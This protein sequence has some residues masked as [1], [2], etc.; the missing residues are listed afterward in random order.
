VLLFAL[1]GLLGLTMRLT[2]ADVLGVSP[3]WFYRIMT[4]HGAG[5]LAGALLAMMG[6]LWLVLR[7][8]VPLSLG[9]MLVSY[10]GVLLGAA[11]VVIATIAGGF[12][13]GWTFLWPLPFSAA[14]EWSLWATVVFLVGMLVIGAGFFI[15]CVDVLHRV[16]TTYGG[17]ARALGI[18]V[19]RG[20]PEEAPPPQA[21]AATVTAIFGLVA[22]AV[23]TTMLMTLVIRAI[24]SSVGIDALWAKNLTY[25]FGHTLANLIIYLGAGVVYVLVP[26][27]AGRPWKTTTPLV[28]GWLITLVL[29][30]SVYSHHLYM[31][32]VQPAGLQYISMAASFGSALPVAVVTIFTG[33]M[34]IWGSR[35][36]WTL[37]STLLYLGFVGW[38]I[39][40]AGAVIDSVIPL[41]FRLHN[42]L[43]VPGHFHTYLLL[44]VILWAL[45][46]LA[47][48]LERAAGRPAARWPAR[49]A[50]VGMLVGGYGLVAAWYVSGALGVPRRYAVHP[51]GTEGYSLAASI[52]TMVFALGFL[53][54]LAEF[55]A[56]ARDGWARRP[57]AA[58]APPA[59]TSE[60][61]A[62]RWTEFR[63]RLALAPSLAAGPQGAGPRAPGRR[64][65]GPSAQ[66]LLVP[67]LATPA[68]L[69]LGM[70]AAVAAIVFFL[71]AVADP[72]EDHVQLHH[73]AHAGQF[74]FGL[75]LGL[76]LASLPTAFA[77]LSRPR[78]ASDAGLAAAIV[79]PLVMLLLM[80][81]SIYES[82]DA[83][84]ALHALYH[85]GIAALGLVTGVGCAVLGR[86]TGFVVAVAS[87]G[88]AVVFA[89]GVTGG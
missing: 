74:L 86:L 72:G 80:T 46:L 35:Y 29:V 89:A 22:S 83:H 39:G 36:R 67:P 41:N 38:A 81:P 11:L 24:D 15:Y 71:P 14:G 44:G 23:G 57:R 2:Q 17:L 70:A 16:T 77:V 59:L 68:Q 6:G 85:V 79:A 88:M 21:I 63:R 31:D 34:L 51:I 45:A 62:L 69:A 20:R 18:P 87:L 52:F 82:L 54:L 42:T 7:S 25:L 3:S 8:D 40:G 9:R 47:H 75:A 32:F 56:L 30:L 5:M 1:M 78:W 60:Q 61:Y 84:P 76:T 50:V 37:A 64:E 10:A 53:I 13:P 49:L 33:M 55:A 27:F 12:A 48:L 26:R 58:P 19:L 43:W 73:L 66:D 65:P 28:V 4:L